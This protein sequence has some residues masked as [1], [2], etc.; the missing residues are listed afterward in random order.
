MCSEPVIRTPR[1][2]CA[3]VYFRRIAINP[4]ISASAMEIS[5][6]PHSARERSA[7]LKSFITGVS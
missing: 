1:N 3:A 7:T 2:G 4:G 6:R 5:L